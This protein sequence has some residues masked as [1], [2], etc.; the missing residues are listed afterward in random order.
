MQGVTLVEM[1][2]SKENP[3]ENRGFAFIEFYNSQCAQWSKNILS[4]HYKVGRGVWPG[5]LAGLEKS[6]RDADALKA[7]RYRAGPVKA[8]GRRFA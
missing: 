2:Q 3:R 8:A 5:P 4:E 1:V 6:K 7:P